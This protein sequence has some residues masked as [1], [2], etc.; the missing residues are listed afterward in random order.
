MGMLM[1]P[2]PKAGSAVRPTS[3]RRWA[4]RGSTV[5]SCERYLSE[6]AWTSA[7]SSEVAVFST[8]LYDV[9]RT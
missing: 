2:P 8:R 4:P 3:R 7:A 9:A 1:K 5:G 6:S